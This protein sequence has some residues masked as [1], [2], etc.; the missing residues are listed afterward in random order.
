MALRLSFESGSLAG[1]HIVTAAPKLRLGRDPQQNDLL[2]TDPKVSRRHAIIE[3]S[4]RGGYSLE[5]LGSGPSTLNGDSIAA[6][7]GRSAVHGLSTGDR[8]G[9]GAIHVVIAE[10]EVRLIV[11]SGSSAGREIFLGETTRVGRLRGDL[12]Y[13][14]RHGKVSARAFLAARLDRSRTA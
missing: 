13:A 2:L 7:G 5:I 10:A 1:T 14:Y 12:T 11:V 8:L 3:R 4:V 6:L 9:F